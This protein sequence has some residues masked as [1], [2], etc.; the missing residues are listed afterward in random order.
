MFCDYVLAF[1]LCSACISNYF[2]F[3][4]FFN[5]NSL[6]LVKNGLQEVSSDPQNSKFNDN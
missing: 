5:F 4:D 6:D 2:Y 3:V 1:M